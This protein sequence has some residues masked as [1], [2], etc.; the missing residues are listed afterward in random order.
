MSKLCVYFHSGAQVPDRA[1][2]HA[3][4]DA[5]FAANPQTTTVST[6]DE[7]ILNSRRD[8]G[9]TRHL[10]STITG[11]T[12]E[13]AIKSIKTFS[14]SRPAVIITLCDEMRLAAANAGI[15]VISTRVPQEGPAPDFAIMK[16][17]HVGDALRHIERNLRL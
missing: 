6:R 2:L 12:A 16:P 3:L 15:R 1:K 4:E 8:E 13:D 7:I 14:G 9:R 5:T 11:A 17:E 10:N